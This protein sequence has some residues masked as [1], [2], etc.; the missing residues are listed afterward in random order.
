MDFTFLK[1]NN[2]E[3]TTISLENKVQRCILYQPFTLVLGNHA[4]DRQE[5]L[6]R[7]LHIVNEMLFVPKEVPPFL[8]SIFFIIRNNDI[9]LKVESIAKDHID[10]GPWLRK[11][12]REF[13]IHFMSII[14][15]RNKETHRVD[16]DLDD[17][18]E[19]ISNE[20]GVKREVSPT[21]ESSRDR[22]KR[23]SEAMLS[24]EGEKIVWSDSDEE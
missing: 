15:S 21:V 18:E 9:T 16:V 5:T 17:E 10:T 4:L 2:T 24:G 1:N 13:S 7:T 3:Y 22:R 11:C 20:S 14:R 12:A 19:T 8:Y 6:Y 23:I